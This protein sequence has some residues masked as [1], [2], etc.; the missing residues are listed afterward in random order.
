MGPAY[1]T[2]GKYAGED[3]VKRFMKYVEDARK[4]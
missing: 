1:E 4:K 2:I 3:N